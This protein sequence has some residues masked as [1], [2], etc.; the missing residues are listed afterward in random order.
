MRGLLVILVALPAGATAQGR[1]RTPPPVVVVLPSLQQQASLVAGAGEALA[2]S[3]RYRVVLLPAL[4][5]LLRQA[6]DKAQVRERARVLV[7]EGRQ[8]LVALDH[9]LAK[10]KLTAALEV[11]E[12]SFLRFYDPR[13]VAEA[14][15]L[16][17]VAAVDMA[18]PDLA[19]QD[20]VAALNLD[21]QL[22]LDAH[23]SP[24]VRA[25][26]AEAGSNLPAPPPPPAD[27]LR[28]VVQLAGAGTRAVVVLSVEPAGERF[29]LKGAL[30]A[31]AK[32]SYTGVESRL[33]DPANPSGVTEE[34]RKVGAQMRR[35]AESFYPAA[36]R[37]VIVKKKDDRVPVNPPPKKRPWYKRWY[38]WAAVAGVVAT[39]G[40]ALPLSLRSKHVETTITW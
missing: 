28:R 16:L 25:A 27:S 15:V 31:D 38:V 20:F 6:D 37:I 13:V 11:L 33:I 36:P 12:K 29:L 32:G 9:A 21:P 39:A 35:M 8:A 2:R 18:R 1:G 17:G 14:R 3:N 4:H 30:Y 40:I 26:F 34:A 23:Y 19:R 5:P 24:Q 22:K 10:A 7:E